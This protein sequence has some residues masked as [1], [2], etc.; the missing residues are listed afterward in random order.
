MK[1]QCGKGMEFTLTKDFGDSGYTS[2]IRLTQNEQSANF[3][4]FNR[5]G[6]NCFR[7]DPTCSGSAKMQKTKRMGKAGIVRTLA[8]LERCK[9]G[10][11][12]PTRRSTGSMVYEA[13]K[14]WKRTSRKSSSSDVGVAASSLSIRA[15]G[16]RPSLSARKLITSRCRN[17]GFANA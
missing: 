4:H 8:C 16:V 12:K 11:R 7:Y 9:N 15:S 1:F 10:R 6:D 13:N 5:G 3:A 17:T 2:S 14:L